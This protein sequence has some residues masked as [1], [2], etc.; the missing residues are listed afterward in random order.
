MIRGTRGEL[1]AVAIERNGFAVRPLMYGLIVMH[2]L[3]IIIVLLC[4]PGRSD[5]SGG[6]RKRTE[7]DLTGFVIEW[8]EK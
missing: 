3:R 7:L 2:D 4:L 6:S 1:T 8:Q 5:M